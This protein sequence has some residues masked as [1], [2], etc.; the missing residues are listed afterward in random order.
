MKNSP[1]TSRDI[2]ADFKSCLPD[3]SCLMRPKI[4][5]EDFTKLAS[6]ASRILS[7]VLKKLIK[8]I[9][10]RVTVSVENKVITRF[11]LMEFS[12]SILR[13]FNKLYSRHR[14]LC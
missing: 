3:T 12:L 4:S 13:N 8:Y 9:G 14:E 6:K 7:L 2:L 11:F 5:F 1:P 10:V